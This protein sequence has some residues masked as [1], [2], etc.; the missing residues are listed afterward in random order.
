M[1]K[2]L[3]ELKEKQL[4]LHYNLLKNGALY[5][6][7]WKNVKAKENKGNFPFSETINEF[8]PNGK[9]INVLNQLEV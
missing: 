6:Y 3:E 5:A 4:V 7:I 2:Y 9:G 1:Y 8:P